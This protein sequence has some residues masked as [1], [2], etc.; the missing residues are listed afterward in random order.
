MQYPFWQVFSEDIRRKVAEKFD[1]GDPVMW[2]EYA[3]AHFC[4]VGYAHYLHRGFDAA[5]PFYGYLC[6]PGSLDVAPILRGIGGQKYGKLVSSLDIG[7]FM[8]ANDHEQIH[9]IW[10]ALGLENPAKAAVAEAEN[11]IKEAAKQPVYA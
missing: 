6:R 11:I 1:G 9:D 2:D 10:E 5:D 8:L 7:R 3:E 4:P